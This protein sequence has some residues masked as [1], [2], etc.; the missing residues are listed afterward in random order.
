MSTKR[1][2]RNTTVAQRLLT[3]S[4]NIEITTNDIGKFTRKRVFLKNET[5]LLRKIIDKT[6]FY[7]LDFEN[8]TGNSCFYN[9]IQ[10]GLLQLFQI[11]VS[12][13][14]IREEFVKMLNIM[15]E[16]F[17]ENI[18][19]TEFEQYRNQS[20]L[21]NSFK[22]VVSKNEWQFQIL[23][24]LSNRK[25]LQPAMKTELKNLAENLI[26]NKRAS[27]YP[28][29][30]VEMITSFFLTERQIQKNDIDHLKK[31]LTN[32]IKSDEAIAICFQLL[33]QSP[34]NF[35]I[36]E[37][38]WSWSDLDLVLL[39]EPNLKIPSFSNKLSEKKRFSI[40]LWYENNYHYKAFAVYNNGTYVFAFK[41]E[42]NFPTQSKGN[43]MI[44][45]QDVIPQVP[46]IYVL[47]AGNQ[48]WRPENSL[49]SGS[50][51]FFLSSL[52]LKLDLDEYTFQQF[53]N[54]LENNDSSEYRQT[55][56]EEKTKEYLDKL[57]NLLDTE[58]FLQSEKNH[59][60]LEQND[61]THKF[62]VRFPADTF[63][64]IGINYI[65]QIDD[66]FFWLPN[67]YSKVYVHSMC[68][69]KLKFTN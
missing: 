61:I 45:V 50:F 65:Y 38:H 13:T 57:I 22:K 37:T 29:L 62:N 41:N 68:D 8:P 54:D 59:S 69:K 21:I 12:E 53:K 6:E 5:H 3:Q 64:H 46:M 11:N 4:D 49:A 25:N 32:Q 51:N 44:S 15:K 36:F 23:I 34:V 48:I 24:L 43:T 39:T 42:Y 20:S 63:P 33:A 55:L 31:I 30:N 28:K 17:F 10:R 16:S 26:V 2:L 58:N 67:R 47:L 56:G 19:Q 52:N 9:C 1:C 66:I 18:L 35:K 7:T 14:Q 27:D 40:F 60:I